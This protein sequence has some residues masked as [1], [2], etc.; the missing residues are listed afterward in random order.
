MARAVCRGLRKRH[1]SGETANGATDEGRKK[2][3][4]ERRGERVL[5]SKKGVHSQHGSAGTEAAGR[6]RTH[7]QTW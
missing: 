4:K 7:R 3:K 2:E 6:P 1:D 5:K